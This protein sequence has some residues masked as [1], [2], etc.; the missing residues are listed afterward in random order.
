MAVICS[1]SNEKWRESQLGANEENVDKAGS[2]F[3]QEGE[4][5]DQS[6]GHQRNGQDNRRME[7]NHGNQIRESWELI[8]NDNRNRRFKDIVQRTMGETNNLR[9]RIGYRKPYPEW[10]N[11]TY[12]FPRGFRFPNFTKISGD[13][14]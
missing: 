10:I 9:E 8:N 2:F 7:G 6:L 12:E 14:H 4:M 13:D 1:S 5:W 3:D 11:Q